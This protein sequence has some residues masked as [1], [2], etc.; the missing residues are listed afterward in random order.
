MPEKRVRIA[1]SDIPRGGRVM[2]IGENADATEVS[3]R[4]M[5]KVDGALQS[6]DCSRQDARDFLRDTAGHAVKRIALGKRG[7]SRR[8]TAEASP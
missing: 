7:A 5:V 1:F 6:F 2:V 3:F 4:L 8:R